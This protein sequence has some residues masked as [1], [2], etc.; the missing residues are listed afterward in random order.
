N[1]SAGDRREQQDRNARAGE[2][3]AVVEVLSHGIVLLSCIRM[4]SHVLGV[5]RHMPAEAWPLP[6][7][8]RRPRTCVRGFV[9]AACQPTDSQA[10][11]ET[12]RPAPAGRYLLPIVCAGC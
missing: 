7:L 9:S 2:G 12:C 6:R 3:P 10:S 11:L 8:G 5:C 4:Y 1:L